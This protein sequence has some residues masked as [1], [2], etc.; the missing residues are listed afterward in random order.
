MWKVFNVNIIDDVI[1]GKVIVRTKVIDKDLGENLE[2][3]Y[4]IIRL[5]IGGYNGSV[6]FFKWFDMDN[7]W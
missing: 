2:L 5:R 4:V 3:I 6:D 1:L 7:V